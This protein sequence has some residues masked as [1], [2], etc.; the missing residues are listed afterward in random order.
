MSGESTSGS[1]ILINT[2]RRGLKLEIFITFTIL[3][4]I[5]ILPVILGIRTAK[6]RNRSPHWMWFGIYPIAGWVAFL[7]LRFLPERKVCGSCG[8]KVDSGAR[9]CPACG[10]EYK[11]GTISAEEEP[12]GKSKII[13]KAAV[14]ISIIAAFIAVLY[15]LLLL[16]FTNSIPYRE[17]F[18]IV[19]SNETVISALGDDVKRKGFIQGSISTNGGGTG[20]AELSFKVEGSKGRGRLYLS[21][22]KKFGTWEFENL[23]LYGYDSTD[24]AIDL[25]KE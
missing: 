17:A 7:I 8:K 24:Q 16:I 14:I 18:R 21:S 13:I 9:F 25:L 23:Y 1:F 6:K 3:L 22:E 19:N 4:L 12:S 5:W 20:S 11:E 2:K 10:D 15:L